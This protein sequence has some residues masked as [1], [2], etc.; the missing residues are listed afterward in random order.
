MKIST[1]SIIY[2]HVVRT[3]QQLWVVDLDMDLAV[4]HIAGLGR[5]AA[6]LGRIAAGLAGSTDYL[7]FSD[8]SG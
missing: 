7:T 4:G 5:T 8:V 1:W 6:G 2:N 3:P